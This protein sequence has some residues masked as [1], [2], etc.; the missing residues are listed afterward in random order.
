[1]KNTYQIYHILGLKIKTKNVKADSK[2][3]L[4]EIEDGRYCSE[5]GWYLSKKSATNA[6]K[7]EIQKHIKYYRKC[8]EIYNKKLNLTKSKLTKLEEGYKQTF[9]EL[10]DWY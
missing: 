2:K 3:S 8:I 1:M 9:P 6:L 5:C 10:S 7:K 4:R